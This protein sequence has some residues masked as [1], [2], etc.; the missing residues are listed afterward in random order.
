MRIVLALE[1]HPSS[2]G[3]VQSHVRDL[4]FNL[5]KLGHEVFIIS[6]N[7]SSNGI[8]GAI[9]QNNTFK[10]YTIESSAPFSTMITL[11]TLDQLKMLIR[12][13]DPDIVHA[14]HAFTPIPLLS[15]HFAET[16]NI[17]RILTNHSITI[18]YE[19]ER[20]WKV[21]SYI[22]LPYRYYIS[23]AQTIISVSR[24]A[25]KFISKFVG[26]D[27]RRV[28]IPNGVDTERFKPPKK[29]PTTPTI[30]F[31][32]RLVYRKGVHVLLKAFSLVVREEPD[33]KLV[34]AGKG[35]MM[36]I[37]KTLAAKYGIRDKVVFKGYVVE[38]SKIELYRRSSIV[39]VPSIFG[40]SFGIV[41]IEA[42]ASGRPVIASSVGGLQEIVS[43]G[44]DGFLVRPNSFKELAEKITILLQDKDLHKRMAVHA[45]AKAEN[46][47]SWKRITGLILGEY[48]RLI[49]GL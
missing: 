10:L 40:E 2:I 34:I 12:K 5:S 33:A 15:L 44:K 3:G 7:S 23:K 38:E 21:S 22:L 48:L 6:K 17:P 32:G 14:H 8:R 35:Y 45:R 46:M 25:D 30:L 24:A 49:E 27:V 20:L 28:V 37:L 19:Y 9:V 42:M 16:Y 26:K 47:Y 4:A 41:A 29:E 31:I 11:S 39:V 13:I 36:S 18:G 1:W 43:D